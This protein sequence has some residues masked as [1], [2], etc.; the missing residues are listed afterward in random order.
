MACATPCT[1]HNAR[2]TFQHWQFATSW[3]TQCGWLTGWQWDNHLHAAR[4]LLLPSNWLLQ[5]MQRSKPWKVIQ[6]SKNLPFVKA[7]MLAIAKARFSTFASQIALMAHGLPM[8]AK[9][10]MTKFMRLALHPCLKSSQQNMRWQHEKHNLG[11]SHRHRFRACPLYWPSRL[12]W[13]FGQII[14]FSFF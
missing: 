5:H 2:A 1:M 3:R 10:T 14:F 7:N 13:R 12:L 9:T 8:T 4:G 11:L 6:T